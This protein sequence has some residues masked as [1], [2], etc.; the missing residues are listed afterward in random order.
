MLGNIFTWLSPLMKP[1]QL[2]A[3]DKLRDFLQ[4]LTS[5]FE[6]SK[7]V[8]AMGEARIDLDGRPNTST[9]KSVC[10]CETLVSQRVSSSNL[11]D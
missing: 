10:I 3:L 4:A 5:F 11:N 6:L 1:R 2:E 9:N 8:K 7:E